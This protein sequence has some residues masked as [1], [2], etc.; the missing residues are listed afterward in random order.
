MGVPH[1][2]VRRR[3]LMGGTALC[4]SLAL[5]RRSTSADFSRPIEIGIQP[6][7]PTALLIKSHQPLRLYFERTFRRPAAISTAPDFATF[8]LRVLRGDFD[9]IVIGPGPGW[10]SHVDRGYPVIAVALRKV[11]VHVLVAKNSPIMSINDLRGKT[12]A[13]IGPTTVSSETIVDLLR[14]YNLQAG[15]DVRI[16]H[17]KNPFNV[18]NSVAMGEVDAAGLSNMS[19]PSLP[20]E[21][22]EKLRI[23][24]VAGDLP[25]ALFLVRPTSD[26]PGPEELQAALFR[27]VNQSA[28]GRA[29]IK[30]SYHDGLVMPDMDALRVLD[31]F[32]PKIRQ[33]ITKP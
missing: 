16:R 23:L 28:E 10:R 13:T 27:F 21:I 20:A 8:Q 11:R 24:H 3:L 14:D 6:Y 17:E 12:L 32:L 25:G 15:T 30:A 1:N 2:A 22:Q 29:Y 9:L 18:A 31:R 19:I 4:A 26:M 33:E 5:P 7:M